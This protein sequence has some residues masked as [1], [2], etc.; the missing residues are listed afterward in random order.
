MKLFFFV[1]SWI[2]LIVSLKLVCP[3]YFVHTLPPYRLRKAD[4]KEDCKLL[5]K[6]YLGTNQAIIP[7]VH[8]GLCQTS[9]MECPKYA[10]TRSAYGF[11]KRGYH[12][13]MLAN[14]N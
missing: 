8:L 2:S 1:S 13:A 10:S 3:S 7:E 14:A 6:K 5:H 9:M 11:G 12:D 4:F